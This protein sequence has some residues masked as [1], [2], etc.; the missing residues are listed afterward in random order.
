VEE[1]LDTLLPMLPN[2]QYYRFNPSKT[3]ETFQATLFVRKTHL[4]ILLGLV[5]ILVGFFEDFKVELWMKLAL[6]LSG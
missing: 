4:S 1:A 5:V 6:S 2:L 3:T